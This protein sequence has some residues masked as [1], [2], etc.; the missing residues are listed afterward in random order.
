[1]LFAAADELAAWAV[2][3]QLGKF[4]F[5]ARFSGKLRRP[6]RPGVEVAGRARITRSS[7]RT[8]EVE[9]TLQQNEELAFA[10]TFTFAVL[11]WQGAE[12]LLGR[13]LPEAW[14]RFSR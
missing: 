6:V 1:L 2:I 9:A 3:A 5:T 11:D 14:R 7:T 4:G 10:G 13:P 12:K 8:A